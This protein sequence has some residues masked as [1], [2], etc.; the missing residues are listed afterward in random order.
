MRIRHL[1]PALL[2]APTLLLA[3]VTP[4]PRVSVGK[5]VKLSGTDAWSATLLS[6]GKFG[7]AWSY[8]AGSWAAIQ[9]D[10][11]PSKVLV[12]WNDVSANWSDLVPSSGACNNGTT[13]PS[14]YRIL[15]SKNSTDGSDGAWDTL[16]RVTG[17]VVAGRS[18][19]IDFAGASWVKMLVVAGSGRMDE[20][21]VYDASN[22]AAD[23]WFF[24][25]TSISMMTFKSP[26][27]DSNF[28]DLVHAR[29]PAQTPSLVRGGVP[30]I[31]ST[32]VL[33]SITAYLDAMVGVHYLAIEMGT[34]DA[35]GGGD[36][37][38]ANYTSNMQKI[39]DSAR[40]RGMEPILARVLPTDSTRTSGNWQVHPG[41]PKAIDSLTKKNNLIA[42]PDLDAWF[43]AHPSELNSDG[44]HPSAT[45]AQSIQRLWA[46]AMTKNLYTQATS[47]APLRRLSGTRSATGRDVLGRP[48]TGKATG[49]KLDG[50]GG[51][52]EIPKR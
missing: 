24:M 32:Q 45:A 11:G 1:A 15:T 10:A 6:D 14:S 49:I 51:T 48:S 44:V 25:G 16:V 52:L 38:L 9:L 20:L 21:E 30:C 33:A 36:W 17:N 28:S 2:L 34:N 31:N 5:T 13:Y 3:A 41:Y 40:G 37:N 42:G 29:N 27:A 4:N 7:N 22:G 46:D 35:W 12:N 43:R 26:V 50:H 47:I 18:H 19:L 23:S 39:I 8:S